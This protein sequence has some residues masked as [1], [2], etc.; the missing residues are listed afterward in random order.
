M[1]GFIHIVNIVAVFYM[2]SFNK[3]CMYQYVLYQVLKA[4]NAPFG[5]IP[6]Q[7]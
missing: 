6:W 5:P 1:Q 2:F 7:D 4:L 3:N